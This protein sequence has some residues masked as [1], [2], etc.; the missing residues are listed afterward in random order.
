MNDDSTSVSQPTDQDAAGTEMEGGGA[1]RAT[2]LIIEDSETNLRLFTDVLEVYGYK[3]LQAKDGATGFAM[4]Q[5]HRPDLIVMDIQLPGMTGLEATK[6]LKA[7]ENL[8]N[9]TVVAVT[10]YTLKGEEQKLWDAGCDDY[11]AKPVSLEKLVETIERHIY[12][13]RS[14]A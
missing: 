8:R 2:V 6:R 11:L 3:T 7:D 13:A 12:G 10:A 9:I 1:S 4:A 5:Q 14:T